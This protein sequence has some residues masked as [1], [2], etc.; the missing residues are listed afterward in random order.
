MKRL[1][2]YLWL[3]VAFMACQT[4]D[5]SIEPEQEQEQEQKQEEEEGLEVV[6]K[7]ER[8]DIQLTDTEKQIATKSNVFAFDLLRTVSKNETSEQ[9][10]LISPLSASMV[11][12]ML[13]NGADGVTKEEIQGTLGYGDFSTEAMNE[14]F[15]KMLAAMKDID[16]EAVFEAANSIWIDSY[17]PVFQSFIDVNKEY[18]DA[19]IRNENF[20]DNVGTTNSINDWC[21]EKT[22]DKI[23]KI[24]DGIDADKVMYLINALYFKA[25]WTIPFD[26]SLTRD[27]TFHNQDGTTSQIPL[28][29]NQRVV[30]YYEDEKFALAEL[31]YGNKAFSMI[32]L[33]PQ[34]NVS[35][36]SIVEKMDAD[37]WAGIINKQMKYEELKLKIPRFRIEYERTLNDDMEEMGMKTMLYSDKANFSLISPMPTF[38]SLVKQKTFAEVNEAGTEAAAVTA[39]GMSNSVGPDYPPPSVK[40]FYVNRP[41]LYIIKEK[42]TGSIAFMGLTKNP[43]YQDLG[44]PVYDY[45]R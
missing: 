39:I 20:K 40:E 7:K 6:E 38:V 9:N 26:K 4:I 10:I 25:A 21:A 29:Q 41:F 35:L 19:E 42:S 30:N 1:F 43:E 37:S 34:T 3:T 22:H 44:E 23:P 12:A 17:F 5:P 15:K 18:Y 27:E 31:P 2:I 13:N 33:L 45:R 24:I 36:S 28:M 32:V 8:V 11:F 16:T 14:Y